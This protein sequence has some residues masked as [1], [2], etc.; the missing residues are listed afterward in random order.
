M[1]AAV[2]GDR[3]LAVAALAQNPL[4]PTESTAVAVVDELLRAHG[5][6]LP[7]FSR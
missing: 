6:Y 1:E 7:Q 2:T 5:E 4:C 3:D